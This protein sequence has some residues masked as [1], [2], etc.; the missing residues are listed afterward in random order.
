M[1]SSAS[2]KGR[3]LNDG[4]PVNCKRGRGMLNSLG[5]LLWFTSCTR[6][7]ND[8]GDAISMA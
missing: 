2:A 5:L 1:G 8:V 4:P 3:M 7:E 6:C